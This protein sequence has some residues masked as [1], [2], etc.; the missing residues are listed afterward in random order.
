MQVTVSVCNTLS[1]HQRVFFFNLISILICGSGGKLKGSIGVL[2]VFFPFFSWETMVAAFTFERHVH[3]HLCRTKERL[4]PAW[5]SSAVTTP[6]REVKFITWWWGR[7]KKACE[8]E[9]LQET[10]VN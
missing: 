5:E 7:G 2:G 8:C 3:D 9:S 6:E 10:G 4:V 1:G